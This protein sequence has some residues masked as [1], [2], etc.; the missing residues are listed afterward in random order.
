MKY[1]I[2]S[3]HTIYTGHK[4]KHD[5]VTQI[6]FEVVVKAMAVVVLDQIKVPESVKSVFF[7]M[8]AQIMDVLVQHYCFFFYVGRNSCAMD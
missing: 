5:F 8:N 2:R 4:R 6:S 3:N 1:C 7:A